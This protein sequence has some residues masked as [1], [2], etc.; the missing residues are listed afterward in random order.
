MGFFHT[1]DNLSLY[2]K[3]SSVDSPQANVVVLHGVGEHIDR[4][5][6][7]FQE[8]QMH[9][10]NCYGFDQR[11]FGRSE[12]ERGHINCIQNYIDD[13][14]D[15]ISQIIDKENEKPIFLFGHSMGC[16][17]VMNY[18]LQQSSSV[19]G[20]ILSSC[21]WKLAKWFAN[22]SGVIGQTLS[23]IAPKFKMPTFIYPEELTDDLIII[24]AYKL[25]P[26]IVDKVSVSW[27][28]E[29]AKARNNVKL[30]AH[31]IRLPTL[32]C[33]GTADPI[34][35]VLGAKQLY[36]HIGS[37]DKTLS[38]FEGFKH[39][40]LNHQVNERTLFLQEIINWLVIHR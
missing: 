15:F 13:L 31:Q 2:F 5:R 27:L 7:L 24:N 35:S 36:Q 28:R 18:A 21:P 9:N 38:V 25:D 11:G 33:H 37:D 40:L 14:A 26:L 19:K 34:A 1:K 4:Y 6:A 23:A 22:Y 3:K 39:E 17:V 30:N 32:V 8:L 12:G 16:I 10:F 29:F 20:L